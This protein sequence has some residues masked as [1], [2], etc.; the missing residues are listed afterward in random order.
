MRRSDISLRYMTNI[1][2]TC[3]VVH[4]MCT[5]GRKKFDIEWIEEAER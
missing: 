4:N 2:A 5:I 3:I 1:V